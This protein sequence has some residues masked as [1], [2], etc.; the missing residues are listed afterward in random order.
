MQE[1]DD[2]REHINKFFDAVDKLE[3]MNVDV[4]PDLL[5]IML[6]YSLPA[7]YENFRCAIESR[8]N[9]PGVEALKIKILEES[10][11]RKQSCS[12]NA[13]SNAMLV[14]MKKNQSSRQNFQK[15]KDDE[16]KSKHENKGHIAARCYARVPPRGNKSFTDDE[17]NAKM[18]EE[19]FLALAAS[20]NI[21]EELEEKRCLDSGCTIHLCKNEVVSRYEANK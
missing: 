6:L 11:A 5:S 13:V 3:E 14:A 4:N 21:P 16:N 1:G 7:S 20:K 12:T 18:L 2:V 15:R 8:D 10:D 19:T 17:G 9:L